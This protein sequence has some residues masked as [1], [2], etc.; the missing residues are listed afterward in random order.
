MP[1]CIVV[2]R[3]EAWNA[4]RM[5]FSPRGSFLLMISFLSCSGDGLVQ[6]STR[7]L[8][9][10]NV[11]MFLHVVLWPIWR[12]L[13]CYQFYRLA[14]S[15]GPSIFPPFSA[16]AMF[17]GSAGCLLLIYIRAPAVTLVIFLF[18]RLLRLDFLLLQMLCSPRFFCRL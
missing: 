1:K 12:P 9:E 18:I 15:L 13:L 17:S 16:V 14:L 2:A 8:D 11:G 5:V 3:S 6:W 10:A 4:D 7:I